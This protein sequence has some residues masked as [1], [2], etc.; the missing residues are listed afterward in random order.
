MNENPQS[1]SDRKPTNQP[2]IVKTMRKDLN[3]QEAQAAAILVPNDKTS[4]IRLAQTVPF[5]KKT[6][7]SNEPGPLELWVVP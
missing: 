6:A 3:Q 1:A 7:T 5:T 4:R 2:T